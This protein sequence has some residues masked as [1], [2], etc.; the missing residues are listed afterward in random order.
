[1]ADFDNNSFD[2]DSDLEEYKKDISGKPIDAAIGAYKSSQSIAAGDPATPPS[3]EE[4]KAVVGH[5]RKLEEILGDMQEREK[6]GEYTADNLEKAIAQAKEAYQD[7]KSRNR[8]AGVAEAIGKGLV[9]YGAARSG[10]GRIDTGPYMDVS[11]KNTQA[12]QEYQDELGLAKDR[13]S[14]SEKA[15]D[16]A[17]S[18]EK[19]I[20]EQN[21]FN[22][23]SKQEKANAKA[24]QTAYSRADRVLAN[25][26]N[27]LQSEARDLSKTQEAT[28][29][30]F[31]RLETEDD[32]KLLK[33]W[34]A[35]NPALAKKAGVDL[36]ELTKK[37]QAEETKPRI[38]GGRSEEDDQAAKKKIIDEYRQASRNSLSSA[39]ERLKAVRQKREDMA[40]GA[41]KPQ[42]ALKEGPAPTKETA[43]PPA[44]AGNGLV[45]MVAPDGR[46]LQ[47]P[48][49]KVKEMES[50]GA[51]R[52]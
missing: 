13:Y 22:A 16:E 27:D 35:S 14:R 3:P 18:L 17:L 20:A 34:A 12:R 28:D 45:R 51:R 31:T 49:D 8:W 36:N 32:P 5:V 37:L 52:E 11:A 39:I 10:A 15:R 33:K 29:E 41:L 1:M 7:E 24:E 25:K 42:E 44:P 50:H 21:E 43:P 38:F 48:E 30:L 2:N 19:K 23:A 40:S 26:E 47:V 6:L 9:Q 4:K 46:K